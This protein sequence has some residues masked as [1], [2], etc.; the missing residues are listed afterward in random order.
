M[1][2]ERVAAVGE[3]MV[4]EHDEAAAEPAEEL[5]KER[6]PASARDEVTGDADEIRTSLR[7][8]GDRLLGRFPPARGDSEMEVGEVRDPQAVQLGRKPFD[9]HLEDTRP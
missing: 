7:D 2:R 1:L 3:V 5:A 8:P 4:P 9:L 6:N